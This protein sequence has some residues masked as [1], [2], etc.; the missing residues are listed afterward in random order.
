LRRDGIESSTAAA[1]S[2]NVEDRAS[3]AGAAL[4]APASMNGEPDP[5]A[6]RRALALMVAAPVLWSIAGVVTRHLSPELQQHGRFEITLWRSFFAALFV[7]AYLALVKRDLAGSLARTGGAGLLSG[8]MWSAMFCCFMLA[9]TLTTV[10]NTLIVLAVAPL[11]TTLLAWAVLG[12]PVPARTWVAI[13][14]AMLGI[15]WMFAEGLR[16]ESGRHLAGMAVAFGVPVASAI[17]VVTLKKRGGAVDLVPAVFIGGV[18]SVLLMLPLA[19]PLRAE[20]RD[21]L[22]LALL[23]V[24]QLGLPCMLMVA[25]ARHLSA[26][27]VAL[28]ALLEVLLGP[29]WAWL[30]AGETPSPAALAGGALVLAALVFNELARSAGAARGSA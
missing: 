9:L 28:L 15:A 29:L 6:H 3:R 22:L 10:A 24:F 14:A 7:G 21:V 16:M 27:E 18:L 19:L 20:P 23:G 13:A 2:R 30:G 5:R 11:L 1:G 26:A 17:N 12:A 25:A 8:L 4:N